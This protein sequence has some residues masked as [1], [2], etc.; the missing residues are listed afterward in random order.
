M[1]LLSKN[2]IERLCISEEQ[3]KKERPP[4]KRCQ[5]GSNNTTP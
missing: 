5:P 3:D 1:Q 4:A 2:K